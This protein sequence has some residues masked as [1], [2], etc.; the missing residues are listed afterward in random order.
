MTQDEIILELQTLLDQHL[1]GLRG[2]IDQEPYKGD[3]FH[4]F[5]D[6]YRNGYFERSSSPLLT[7]DA[8]RDI[9]VERWYDADEAANKNRDQLMDQLFTKWDQWRY[10]WDHY[11]G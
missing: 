9:L 8:L 4:L 10:T 11:E 5:R 6:A 3:F 1:R 7:G 2:Y